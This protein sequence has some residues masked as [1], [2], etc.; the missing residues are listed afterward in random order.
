MP[1]VKQG[2]GITLTF[3]K[4]NEDVKDILDREKASGTVIT[5]YICDAI[6][7]YEENKNDFKA[8]NVTN[9]DIEKMIEHKIEMLLSSKNIELDKAKAED[10]KCIASA[11]ETTYDLEDDEFIDDM[12]L[13]ED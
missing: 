7:F 6:R 1:A 3:S 13:D 2:G 5:N 11:E 10:D 4:K 12:D 8:S 9:L